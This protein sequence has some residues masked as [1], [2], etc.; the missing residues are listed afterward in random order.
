MTSEFHLGFAL[1]GER[2]CQCLHMLLE[3]HGFLRLLLLFHER[4]YERL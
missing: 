1:F 3:D 4:P 2:S